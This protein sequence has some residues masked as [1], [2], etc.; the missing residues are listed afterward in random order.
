MFGGK[1]AADNKLANL[2]W[3]ETPDTAKAG[4]GM[5]ARGM[6]AA[7]IANAYKIYAIDEQT[8]GRKPMDKAEFARMR[9][10]I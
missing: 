10:Y 5:A 6:T 4:S 3:S 9:G 7:Q 8:E 2:V 1:M